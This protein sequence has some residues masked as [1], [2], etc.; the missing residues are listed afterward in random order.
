M[1]LTCITTLVIISYLIMI[2]TI[3]VIMEFMS[4]LLILTISL[5]TGLWETIM[6]YMLITHLI[7]FYGTIIS[8]T[9]ASMHMN[10]PLATTGIL[11][12]QGITGM[13]LK[14]IWVIR[15]ITS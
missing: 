10:L 5:L 9:I 2:S 4:T 1:A 6:V 7:I 8:Q 15:M 12:L 3:V 11:A 13:I 14:R